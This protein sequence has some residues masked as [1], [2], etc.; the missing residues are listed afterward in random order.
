MELPPSQVAFA[1][2]LALAAHSSGL[3]PTPK[4]CTTSNPHV[5]R[6]AVPDRSP[7]PPPPT[8]PKL[9]KAVAALGATA[10]LPG[11]IS[12]FLASPGRLLSRTLSY[13]TGS[14]AP[15]ISASAPT[16]SVDKSQP[17]PTQEPR[18]LTSFPSSSQFPNDDLHE[19][20]DDLSGEGLRGSETGQYDAEISAFLEDDVRA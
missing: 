5:T 13:A 4:E 1:S 11:N 6:N 15:Q 16:P 12:S 3:I 18:L 17:A 8:P 9:A 19:D 10:S 20:E 2:P 7:R 14:S